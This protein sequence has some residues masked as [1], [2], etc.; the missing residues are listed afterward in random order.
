MSKK[1]HNIL[2]GEG[3][4]DMDY[5]EEL[6]LNPALAYTPEINEAIV[7]RIEANNF[8]EYVDQGYGEEKAKAMSTELANRGRA[9]IAE[10]KKKNPNKGVQ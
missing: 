9:N 8:V 3:I 2:S 10:Y 6:G 4:D 1:S 5:V 7:K